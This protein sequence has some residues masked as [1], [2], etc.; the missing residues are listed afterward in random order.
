M[1]K[2]LPI[3]S[4]GSITILII[5][6]NPAN[7]AVIVESLSH[8]GYQVLVAQ[9]GEEGIQRAAYVKPDLILLDV[10]M[11]GIDG[12]ETCKRLKSQEGTASIPVIFMTSLMETEHKLKGFDAGATDY[13]T[14]P[15]QIAEVE[16]RVSLHLKLYLIQKQLSIQN[17]QL[18]HYRNTLEQQV[19]ERTVELNSS[20]LQLRQE[21]KQRRDTEIALQKSEEQFRT[22]AENSPDMIARYDKNGSRIYA[23]P[24]MLAEIGIALNLVL[25]SSPINTTDNISAFSYQKLIQQVIINGHNKSFEQSWESSDGNPI[26]IHMQLSPEFNSS[27]EVVSVLA[28]GRDIT[29]IDLYRRNIHHLAYYDSLT[30]LPNRMLFIERIQEAIN[31]SELHKKQFGILMLDLDRFKEVNDSLGHDVGDLLLLEA[32]RRLTSCVRE[33]DTVSRLGGDEFAIII[34]DIKDIEDL[35]IVAIKILNAFQQSFHIRG[36]DLFVSASIGIVKYPNDSTEIDVLLKYA[37]S[38]MYHAKR[39]GRNNYQFYCASLTAQSSERIALEASLLNARKNGELILYFQPQ[40]DLRDGKVIG[41]EALLRWNHAE[42]GLMMPDRFI[43]ITEETG[44]ILDIGEWIILEACRTAVLWNRNRKTPFT[45]AINLSTRQFVQNNL[46]DSICHTLFETGCKPEW[47]KLEITENLLL[48]DSEETLNILNT[49]DEMGLTIAIDDFGTGYS[50]LSYLTKFPM[51]QLKID[52]SFVSDIPKNR[53]KSELVKAIISIAKALNLELVA[54]GVETIEQSQFLLAN[55]C[56]M[57]QG[58]LY[59]KPIPKDMFEKLNF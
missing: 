31:D 30:E 54:E 45:V 11:P 48:D 33:Y 15:L 51:K 20:N 37:D 55:G 22:L 44:L 6:D 14:K 57:A 27:N 41:A 7:L 40:I 58:Y 42:L 19:S 46:L 16:A 10:M 26:V 56:H 2:D 5:D 43:S 21:I 12:F 32:A 34:A 47:L 9:D 38:A 39:R 36:K 4:Y 50:A 18:E 23:N 8:H 35:K 52:R 49:L 53:D 1:N 25:D 17:K 13:V 29:E 3:L 24:K 59:G 28:I